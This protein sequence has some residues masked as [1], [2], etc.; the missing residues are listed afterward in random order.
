MIKV[1]VVDDH[2]VVVD[3]LCST[4]EDLPGIEV[5]FTANSGEELLEKMPVHTPHI[6][7]LDHSFNSRDGQNM[8]G[9]EAAAE[10]FV[11]FPNVKVLML[12]MH[13]QPEIII[14]CLEVGVQGYM[15][16]SEKQ[17]DIA[18]AITE[19]DQKGAYFSPEIAVHLVHRYVKVSENRVDITSREQEVLELL[20][21]GC[22]TT[23]VAEKLFISHHT[24][25]SHR[26]SLL[27]KFEAKN[28]V[29][30]I[31]LALQQKFIQMPT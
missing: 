24:V 1:A 21:E 11:R 13:D 23:E 22:S 28:S 4:L 7:I 19:L 29:H 26:K 16:K 31:Y 2:Q 30:L 3:G 27:S 25:E 10:I 17:F 18:K 5:V 12:T 20:F 8:N 6:V 15:L 14:P 9:R